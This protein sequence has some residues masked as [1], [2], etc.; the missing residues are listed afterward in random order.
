MRI[1]LESLQMLDA[2][3]TRGSFAAAA[4]ALFRVPSALTH[5][6]KKLEEDLGVTLFVREGRR[7]VMTPAGRMLLDEGRHLLRAA[8]DLECR[9]KRVATGWES[10]LRVALF[11]LVPVARMLP[12]VREFYG[13]LSGTRLKLLT[14]VLGGSWDALYTGRADLSIGATGDAPPGGGFRSIPLG[15]LEF[16]FVTA[17]DHPLARMR[18]PLPPSAIQQHRAV[19]LAD[20]SRQL[21]ARTTGLISGQDVLTVPDLDAKVEAHAAGIGVGYLP[22]GIAEREAAAGRLV[23]RRVAEARPPVMS[24]IAWRSDQEGNALRWFIERLSDPETRAR[25]LEGVLAG[26]GGPE[27]DVRSTRRGRAHRPVT[28]G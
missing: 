20:T 7:A 3:D 10:E 8:G 26:T 6:I 22:A 9:L 4:E 18:E 16:V 19:A 27:T 25:L 2:I 11:A 5:A 15:T 17:P 14:E 24:Y 23:I 12:L 28:T 21:L 13:Q 1:T